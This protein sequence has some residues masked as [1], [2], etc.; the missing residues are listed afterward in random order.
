[1]ATVQPVISTTLLHS[2]KVAGQRGSSTPIGRIEG[3]HRKPVLNATDAWLRLRRT[4]VDDAAYLPASSRRSGRRSRSIPSAIDLIGHF[5]RRLHDLS[6]GLRATPNQIAAIVSLAGATFAKPADCAPTGPV[7]VLEIHGTAT[8]RSPSRADGP[9][10][11]MAAFPGAETS[12]A[13]WA[14]TTDVRQRRRQ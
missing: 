1:M 10:L 13:T 6:D 2:D 5:E 9:N 8:T 4:G 14:S 11:A 12:V 7:A 3:R